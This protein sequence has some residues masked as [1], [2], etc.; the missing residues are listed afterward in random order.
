MAE[1]TFGRCVYSNLDQIFHTCFLSLIPSARKVKARC[2]FCM[3]C[4]VDL[5]DIQAEIMKVCSKVFTR[6]YEP[7]EK[8]GI[9]QLFYSLPRQ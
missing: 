5:S 4:A 9:R 3:T 8:N 1:N 7:E 2:D 6:L